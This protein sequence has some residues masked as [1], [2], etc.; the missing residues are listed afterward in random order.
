MQYLNTSEIDILS[1]KIQPLDSVW[2]IGDEFL[3]ENVYIY[4]NMREDDTF[5][6]A[7]FAAKFFTSCA[8]GSSFT[9]VAARLRNS[10]AKAL[11]ELVTPL[12]KL[13]MFILED[14]IIRDLYTNGEQEIWIKYNKI[15][16]WLC[17]EVRKM[18]A[19]HNDALPLNARRLV[20]VVWV[21]PT[22]HMNY[23]NNE[24]RKIFT[25]CL[26][27]KTKLQEKQHAFELRHVWDSSDN[28]IFLKR[29]RRFTNAGLVAYFRA[30]DRTLLFANTV[31]NKTKQ[32]VN[33]PFPMPQQPVQQETYNY[34][35]PPSG[36]RP[37]MV[38]KPKGKPF[39]KYNPK[40]R[41]LPEPRQKMEYDS[42]DF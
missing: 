16:N 38:N 22:Q 3:H 36:G 12:P 27:N 6:P 23:P 26:I 28:S 35:N 7:N 9:S 31:A 19:G 1:E 37:K 42:V 32:A 21:I 4:R 13:I 24:G 5:L 41:Q 8:V 17:N 33:I 39:W 20:H 14:D 40:G 25:T 18:L 30:L 10:M 15:C 2:M 11:R 29:E 34:H